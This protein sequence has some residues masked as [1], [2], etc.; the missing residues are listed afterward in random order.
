MRGSTTATAHSE[1]LRLLLSPIPVLGPLLPE[2]FFLACCGA[3]NLPWRESAPA[4]SV[5]F[6]VHTEVGLM[7]VWLAS[8]AYRIFEF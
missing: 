8:A 2:L 5:P 6:A 7:T 3:S 4:I 1:K